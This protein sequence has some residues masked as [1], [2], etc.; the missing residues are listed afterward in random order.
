M[1]LFPMGA[2]LLRLVPGRWSFRLHWVVQ[3]LAWV[4]YIAAAALGLVLIGRVR[5]PGE[6]WGFVSVSCCYV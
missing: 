4:L 1:I 3:M 2:I 6:D 5:F